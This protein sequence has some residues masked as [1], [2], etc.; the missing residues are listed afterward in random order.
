MTNRFLFNKLKMLEKMKYLPI[1]LIFVFASCSNREQNN[2]I[3]PVTNVEEIENILNIVNEE[4]EQNGINVYD[5]RMTH[6]VTVNLRLR[7][8]DNLSASIITVLPA[9]T[10][11][12]IIETGVTETIDGITAPWIRVVSEIGYIG[13][14]FSG[15]ID[16]L[17][18]IPEIIIEQKTIADFF[19]D[20]ILSGRRYIPVEDFIVKRSNE[21][22]LTYFGEPLEINIIPTNPVFY[23]SGGRV[24]EIHE[25]I[26]EDLLHSF[27]VFENEMILYTALII[28]KRLDRLRTINIGDSLELLLSTFS[29]RYWISERADAITITYD[30]D[31]LLP[32]IEFVIRDSVIQRIV[33]G[34]IPY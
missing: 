21:G 6:H 7:D 25:Y 9:N 1:I 29:D 20:E 18:V 11:I 31:P 14:I 10:T 4:F 2:K 8:G 24:I 27:L 17:D 19:F 32:R 22:I 33:V 30:P 34:F 26:Y 23:F 12:R 15:H 28:K 3:N 13:W 5:G 16:E